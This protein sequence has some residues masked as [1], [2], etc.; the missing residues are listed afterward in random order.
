MSSVI[1]LVSLFIMAKGVWQWEMKGSKKSVISGINA[2]DFKAPSR[3]ANG[4][5]K[6]KQLGDFIL[7]MGLRP[8]N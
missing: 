7:I 3:H 5:L 6:D 8:C 2:P 1:S 4:S